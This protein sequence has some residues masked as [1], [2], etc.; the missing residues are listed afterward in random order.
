MLQPGR[1]TAGQRGPEP[2]LGHGDKRDDSRTA[3]L[4]QRPV[5]GAQRPA[6]RIGLSREP[7]RRC[8]MT[9]G[10]RGRGSCVEDGV[11]EDAIFFLA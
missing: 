3:F 1:T 7:K 8:Q 6:S 4:P 5:R 2:Q 10:P 9:T 11:K